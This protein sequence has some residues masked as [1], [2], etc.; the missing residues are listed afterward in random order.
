MIAMSDVTTRTGMVP[1]NIAELNFHR[2]APFS[3]LSG[4]R[5]CR[6]IT[7]E[8]YRLLRIGLHHSI[9]RNT[10]YNMIMVYTNI[11]KLKL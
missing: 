1:E 9:E 6:S 5:T 11:S 4:A 7:Q 2:L 10:H 3:H 8:R